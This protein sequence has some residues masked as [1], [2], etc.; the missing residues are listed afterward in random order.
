MPGIPALLL[1]LLLVL[2]SLREQLSA[3]T[4]MALAVLTCTAV[5]GF[6]GRMTIQDSLAETGASH[7]V[8]ARSS[9][10][11]HQ[12]L[13]PNSVVIS[14][15]MSAAL[16]FYSNRTILRWDLTSPE[17]WKIIST[18]LKE[19]GWHCYALLMPHEIERAQNAL[20]GQWKKIGDYQNVSLW[21]VETTP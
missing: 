13:P 21:Q 11:A 4:G 8:H 19:S 16:R 18:R 2:Q 7:Y 9:R 20:T 1:G 12:Q 6:G 5:L 15:E 3:K 17:R 14:E 10:W